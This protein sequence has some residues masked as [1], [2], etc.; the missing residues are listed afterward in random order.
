MQKSCDGREVGE[1]GLDHQRA[2]RLAD[3]DVG[4]RAQRF[5][6]G[7]AG[8][9]PDRAA[10]PFDDQLHDA[11]II[12][13]RDQRGEE[14]DHRQGR[15]REAVGADLGRGERAEDEVGAG[16]GVA[17]QVGDAARHRADHALAPGRA[18]H[19]HRERRPAARRRRRRRAGGSSAGSTENRNA[20]ARISSDAADPDQILHAL[21]PGF[22]SVAAPSRGARNYQ[23]IFGSVAPIAASSWSIASPIV[24]GDQQLRAPRRRH[25]AARRDMVEE[26]DHPVPEAVDVEQGERLGV[27]AERVPAPRLEQFVERADAAGNGDE[28]V[29]QL[30]HHRLALVHVGDD[31]EL[32][33][34]GMGDLEVDQRLRDH[35]IGLA[36]ARPSPRRRPRPSAR[37][38]R[39]HRRGRCRAAAISSPSA[40]AVSA[41]RGSVP[42]LEPQ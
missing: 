10:D 15:D 27:I 3:E 5:D 39:R 1:I 35:A 18:E 14:D 13:D 24:V 37:A 30:G 12:E 34:A 22:A 2:F 19:Q 25:E 41:K 17:E 26:G 16:L 33:E 38:G 28:G 4:R 8:H 29:G 31:V 36:A 23:T 6:A 9:Q 40:R 42:M 11:E 7:D 20:M 21:P 32:G